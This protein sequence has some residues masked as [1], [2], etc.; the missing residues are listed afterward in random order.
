MGKLHVSVPIA[1]LLLA[2]VASS[3]CTVPVLN[4]EIPGLPDFPGFGT[5]VIQ[6]T[7]DII[8]IKSMEIVPD[9][10]DSGQ[11]AQV[12]A[13]IQ[14]VGDKTVGS[15]NTGDDVK[16]DLYDYCEGLFTPKLITCGAEQAGRTGLT[17][18][19]CR[20]R[21]ILPGEIVPVIWSATQVGGVNVK[22]VCPTEGM[23]MSVRYHYK[24]TSLTT[25]SLISL[26]EMQREM[27]ERRYDT[28]NGYISLGQGPIKPVLTVEDKQPVPVFDD[29]GVASADAKARTVLMLRLKNMGSG[30][31]DSKKI[32]DGRSVIAIEGSK[33]TVRG[34]GNGASDLKPVAPT[35]GDEV[36]CIFAA[37]GGSQWSSELVRLVGKESSPYYCKIDLSSLASKVT[38]TTSRHLEVDVEYDYLITKNALVTIDPKI[39]V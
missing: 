26:A 1:A 21:R 29:S 36:P 10:I 39:S 27:I 28:D 31:L 24:T 18:T 35:T 32:V 20:I 6:D 9:T 14:N 37:G 8:V 13:Y 30:Q 33:I 22:T 3:G 16:V 34:I 23:K 17:A 2:M 4:I 7:S 11:T 12:L 5:P 15:D 25:I 19:E 38:T